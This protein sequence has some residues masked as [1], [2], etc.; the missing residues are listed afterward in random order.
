VRL[1]VLQ[2]LSL[3]SNSQDVDVASSQNIEEAAIIPFCFPFGM[4][5]RITAASFYRNRENL[6]RRFLLSGSFADATRWRFF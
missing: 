5:M 3:L 1:N 4:Q 2:A 6:F